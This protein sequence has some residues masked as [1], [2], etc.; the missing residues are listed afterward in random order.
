M[1]APRSSNTTRIPALDPT[2]ATR[3]E[4]ESAGR[5]KMQS[6]AETGSG[7]MRAHISTELTKT[8]SLRGPGLKPPKLNLNRIKFPNT[9]PTPGSKIMVLTSREATGL[10]FPP[11]PAA[12]P[13]LRTPGRQPQQTTSLLHREPARLSDS[14]NTS[15]LFTDTGRR[16]AAVRTSSHQVSVQRLTSP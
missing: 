16:L 15:K 3:T 1:E 14:R 8:H 10:G 9:N 6:G 11:S 5:M 13:F 4:V 7:K 12:P 2:T